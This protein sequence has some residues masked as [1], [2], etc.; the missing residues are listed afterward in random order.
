MYFTYGN[1]CSDDSLNNGNFKNNFTKFS[2]SFS[3]LFTGE[4]IVIAFF[5][6]GED[7]ILLFLCFLLFLFKSFTSVNLIKFGFI[8][9]FGDKVFIKFIIDD[10]LLLLD[11]GE[12]YIPF[13][14]FFDTTL[15]VSFLIS[16]I[17]SF[18]SFEDISSSLSFFFFI[19]SIFT[20]IVSLF[21][22][23]IFFWNFL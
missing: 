13:I 5:F 6:F 21:I 7:K 16:N 3:I 1:N 8:F 22:F 2:I 19:S 23:F 4:F 20:F 9:L 15:F 14:F 18:D 10:L 11:K 17:I 12:L